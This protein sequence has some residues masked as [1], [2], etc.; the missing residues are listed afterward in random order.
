MRS[1][2][3]VNYVSGYLLKDINLKPIIDYVTTKQGSKYGAFLGVDYWGI[4]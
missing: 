2:F 3:V 1:N 4:I